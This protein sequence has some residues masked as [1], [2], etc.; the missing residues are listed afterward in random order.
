MRNIC[1]IGLPTAG[2]SRIGNLLY[3]HLRKGFIDTDTLLSQKYNMPLSDIIK[4]HGVDD[5]LD[6]ERDMILSLNHNN[7]VLAT[8]GSVIY[9]GESIHHIK[10]VLN[11]DIYYLSLPKVDFLQRLYPPLTNRI[12]TSSPVTSENLPYDKLYDERDRLYTTY[13]DYI[14]PMDKLYQLDIFKRQ[15]S[16][17][18]KTVKTTSGKHVVYSSY[19]CP[20]L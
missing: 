11:A 9:R 19:P 5:Y 20:P 15:R 10:D 4:T 6:R 8:G 18:A 12:I 7:V 3:K 16:T 1:L 13:A 14:V 17:T 2:K